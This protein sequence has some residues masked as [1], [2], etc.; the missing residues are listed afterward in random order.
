MNSRFASFGHSS[1]VIGGSSA[2]IRFGNCV[3]FF[4]FYNDFCARFF[5]MNNPRLVLIDKVLRKN[6]IQDSNIE[7]NTGFNSRKNLLDSIL[8]NHSWIIRSD[9]CARF[10]IALDFLYDVLNENSKLH[11]NKS[12]YSLF[13]NF[14][15]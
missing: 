2:K 7:L 8:G 1:I 15:S 5:K 11:F 4:K 12:S 3:G 13:T 9:F 14:G 10:K 6:Q